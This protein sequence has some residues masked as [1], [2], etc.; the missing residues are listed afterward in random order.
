MNANLIKIK[1]N[2]CVL[3]AQVKTV[4]FGER[5]NAN[6]DDNMEKNRVCMLN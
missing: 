4:K 3:L 1:L 2:H 5:L 6:W